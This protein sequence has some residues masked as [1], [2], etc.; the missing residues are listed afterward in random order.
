MKDKKASKS[1]IALSKRILRKDDTTVFEVAPAYENEKPITAT[2][3][4]KSSS[5]WAKSASKNGLVT[6]LV[7]DA[8]G[9]F[10]LATTL[11]PELLQV[12][13]EMVIST[14]GHPELT[15]DGLQEMLVN[16]L[17]GDLAVA[18]NKHL[19]AERAKK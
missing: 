12:L 19:N 7:V 8:S 6:D 10:H 18:M 1:Q 4:T 13:S 14:E 15:V 2:I 3:Y 17:Y 9:N 11:D 16:P 5:Q